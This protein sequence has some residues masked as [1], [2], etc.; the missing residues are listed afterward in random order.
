[1]TQLLNSLAPVLNAPTPG[2]LRQFRGDLLQAGVSQDSP[3]CETLEEFHR[4][5][6]LLSASM[7]ARD[8]SRWATL[9]DIGAIGGLAVGHILETYHSPEELW[10]RLLAGAASEGLMVLASR[11]YVKAFQTEI[12]AVHESA[13]WR[14]YGGFWHL[15]ERLRPELSPETRRQQ[16][17]A[18]LDPVHDVS[19]PS[20]ARAVMIGLLYQLLL[21]I[22]LKVDHS[23]LLP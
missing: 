10:K 23:D 20:S 15:S 19:P 2:A 18:L 9:M 21:L 11:Q 6:T 1:M 16:I 3:L 8:Y 12:G 7:T 17:D 22:L 5:L 4:F 13:A 14:L